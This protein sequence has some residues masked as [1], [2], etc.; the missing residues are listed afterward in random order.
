MLAVSIKIFYGDAETIVR[1]NSSL[2]QDTPL[3]LRLGFP[4]VVFPGDVRNELY[5]KLWSGDFSASQS[6]GTRR[7][8]AAFGRG[9][10]TGNVQVSMEVRDQDGRKIDR[11]I[12][13]CSG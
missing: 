13:Q 6:S 8:V 11:V 4:D 7:N 3:S 5:I 1:E 10:F 12:S 9:P 2:L